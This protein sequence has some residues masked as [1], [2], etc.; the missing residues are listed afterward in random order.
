MPVLQLLFAV[1]SIPN[2]RVRFII[3]EIFQLVFLRKLRAQSLFVFP[4]SLGQVSRHPNIEHIPP[5]IRKNI[6][7]PRLCS[8]ILKSHSTFY[9]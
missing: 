1:Y 5:L 2:V 8:D 3:N 9:W 6:N 4:Y 7:I